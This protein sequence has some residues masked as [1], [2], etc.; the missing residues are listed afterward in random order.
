MAEGPHNRQWML[1]SPLRITACT[2]NMEEGL[3]GKFKGKEWREEGDELGLDVEENA[4]RKRCGVNERVVHTSE[5]QSMKA[6]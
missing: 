1:Q 4:M 3:Y 2:Q 5:Q 6:F